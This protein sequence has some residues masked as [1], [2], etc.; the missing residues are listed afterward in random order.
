MSNG[1]VPY[2]L[3]QTAVSGENTHLLGRVAYFDDIDRQSTSQVPGPTTGMRV[4]AVWVKNTKA[5]ALLP[6][7]IARWEAGYVGTRTDEYNGVAAPGA[8]VVDH[9]LPA[10]GVAAGYHYWLIQE[11]PTELIHAGNDTL[12]TGSLLVTAAA[13][14]VDLYSASDTASSES[15]SL[16]GRALENPAD[17][18]GTVFRAYVNFRGF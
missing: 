16:I 5:T 9:N 15:T 14:R 13:G 18:A 10:A 8:G 2:D 11:G 12:T 1:G 4:K 3:G 7:E 17:V 6:G